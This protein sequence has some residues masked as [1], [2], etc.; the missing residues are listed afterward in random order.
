M[1]QD[2]FR[3]NAG[4]IGLVLVAILV[5]A[6]LGLAFSS[7]RV[8]PFLVIPVI[9]ASVIGS[10]RTSAFVSAFAIA[11]MLV[12]NDFGDDFEDLGRQLIA[13]VLACAI[14]IALAWVIGRSQRRLRAEQEQFRLLAE[15][16]SDIVGRVS[17]D[18]MVEWVSP[19]VQAVLGWKPEDLRG[20]SQFGLVHPDDL[21][22]ARAA[23]ES[24]SDGQAV[25]MSPTVMRFATSG[26]EYRWMSAS[27]RALPDQAMA[28]SLRQVEDE[29]RAVAALSD[30]EAQFRL[31]AENAMDLVFLTD[32]DGALSWVSPS[33]TAVLGYAPEEIVGT[34]PESLL[35]AD[36]VQVYRSSVQ[37]V[38]RLRT[39]TGL[40][41][42]RTWDGTY[43]WV[44]ATVR[45]IRT[46]SGEV[47][48]WVIAIRDVGLEHEAR[49]ALEHWLQFDALTGL[50]TRPMA[51][52]R[53]S[54]L[55]DAPGDRS[56]AL[57]CVSIDGMTTTNQAYTYASG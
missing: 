3:S 8:L 40:M 25:L 49:T 24:R 14:S 18:G 35:H 29:M 7:V 13:L 23:A 4:V 34:Q 43:I 47:D 6:I 17:E 50:A 44:E 39:S 56:W 5:V 10:M 32:A 19:S 27:V 9:A 55:L 21:A 33:V 53:V 31:L 15:N 20:S 48:G 54:A 52:K 42:L 22:T 51:L 11:T 41:R 38:S 28:V 37:L 57:L 16:A 36:D 2:R 26:G 46:P 30:S 1:R 12:L 45:A